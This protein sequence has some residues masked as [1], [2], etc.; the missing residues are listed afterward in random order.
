MNDKFDEVTKDLAQ[1]VTR[2][3]A[4]KKFSLGLLGAMLASLVTA[5]KAEARQSCYS[6]CRNQCTKLYPRGTFDWQ[7]CYDQCTAN[8]PLGI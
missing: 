1:S 3:G 4:L 8:C 2:R 6:H 7:V 5:N